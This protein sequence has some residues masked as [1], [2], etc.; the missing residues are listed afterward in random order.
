MWICV[1]GMETQWLYTE[2]KDTKIFPP[3]QSLAVTSVS[4]HYR[5]AVGVTAEGPVGGHSRVCA[6]V[7]V[8]RAGVVSWMSFS[9]SQGPPASSS[10]RCQEMMEVALHQV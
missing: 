10:K 9:S 1:L 5:W 4:L 6:A 7:K 8:G 2:A 3:L